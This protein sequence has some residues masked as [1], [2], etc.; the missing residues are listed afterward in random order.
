[1]STAIKSF[2]AFMILCLLVDSIWVVGAGKLHSS[3]V[4]RVQKTE[5]KVDPLP[6]LLFYLLV[7]LA[8]VFIIKKLATDFKSAFLYG[9][10]IGL[11]MYGTFDLTNK[12]IFKDYPWSYTIADMTWGTFVVGLVSAITFTYF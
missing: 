6:A 12:A 2:I 3:V 10:L 8:Y 4:Q 1:M 7:P 9:L 5:L 11:L